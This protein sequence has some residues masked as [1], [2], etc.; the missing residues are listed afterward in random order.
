MDFNAI[1]QIALKFILYK[2]KPEKRQKNK[3]NITTSDKYKP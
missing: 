3:K 2:N 1:N